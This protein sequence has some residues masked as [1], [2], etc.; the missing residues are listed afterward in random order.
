MAPR[1]LR[2]LRPFLH[3]DLTAADNSARSAYAR[4]LRSPGHRSISSCIPSEA[5]EH[6]EVQKR[7]S[8][9]QTGNFRS[10]PRIENSESALTC[11]SFNKQYAFIK[12]GESADDE[13]VTVRGA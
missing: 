12:P 4:I 9:L 6:P 11:D 3:R 1:S 7:I 10:Y 8:E 2:F 5:S 13:L